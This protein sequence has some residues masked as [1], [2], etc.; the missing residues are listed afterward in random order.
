MW[1]REE[2]NL[3]LKTAIANGAKE[4]EIADALFHVAI[5]PYSI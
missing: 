4:S 2:F 1:H 3:N 5:G